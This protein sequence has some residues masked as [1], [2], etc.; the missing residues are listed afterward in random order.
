LQ[1]AFTNAHTKLREI[2]NKT[3]KVKSWC[4]K[5]IRNYFSLK[6]VIMLKKKYFAWKQQ[7]ARVMIKTTKWKKQS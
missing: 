6:N 1:L 4:V 5:N 7:R 2:H 3:S